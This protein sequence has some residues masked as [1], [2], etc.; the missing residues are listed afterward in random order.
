MRQPLKARRGGVAGE[1]SGDEGG[2]VV[3]GEAAVVVDV[4][5]DGANLGVGVE[6]AADEFGHIVDAKAA[7]VIHV[8]PEGVV[9]V[10]EDV[11]KAR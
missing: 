5:T 6:Q 3:D 7:V 1:D 11:F 8:T 4:G 2:H 9:V 10:L